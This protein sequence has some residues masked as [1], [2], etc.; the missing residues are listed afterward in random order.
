MAT[1][2]RRDQDNMYD[3]PDNFNPDEVN[4]DV[5]A[6]CKLQAPA[7]ET[8]PENVKSQSES[9][10]PV[11]K[12]KKQKLDDHEFSL[13]DPS[14]SDHRQDDSET[15]WA[16]MYH[17]LLNFKGRYGHCFVHNTYGRLGR[18]CDDQ[19]AHYKLFKE[20][21]SSPMT[22]KKV[23]MLN[24]A[25]FCWT[26]SSRREKQWHLMYDLLVEFKESFG[27]CNVPKKY[28]SNTKLGSWVDYQRTLYRRQLNDEDSGGTNGTGDDKSKGISKERIEMLN[29]IGFRWSASKLQT[30]LHLAK[31]DE[32]QRLVSTSIN[33]VEKEQIGPG[34]VNALA[35]LCSAAALKS[36]DTKNQ[37][38]EYYKKGIEVHIGNRVEAVVINSGE[39]MSMRVHD[40][41]SSTPLSAAEDTSAGGAKH[42]V[43][44]ENIDGVNYI[45]QQVP[46]SHSVQNVSQIIAHPNYSFNGMVRHNFEPEPVRYSPLNNNITRK[47]MYVV[48]NDNQLVVSHPDTSQLVPRKIL[49]SSGA[50]IVHRQAQFPMHQHEA[51]HVTMY[52][53]PNQIRQ[54]T[55][56]VPAHNMLPRVSNMMSNDV[57]NQPIYVLNGNEGVAM[58]GKVG[59]GGQ[60]VTSTIF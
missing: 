37:T 6:L 46:G 44:S 31:E 15:L 40:A 12:K 48:G 52:R 29:M 59:D 18:W 30:V 36:T 17:R 14:F 11:P 33:A 32:D 5:K 60:M 38:G 3:I 27:H 28:K 10:S 39:R 43:T 20:G 54:R 42:E 47:V 58:N 22:A 21:K 19:R 49:V 34:G 13:D 4:S 53:V 41:T 51:R 16:F 26:F 45:Y 50:P 57:N 8:S 7:T 24:K 2:Q 9:E 23:G 25:G 55:T 35:M 56:L 1:K